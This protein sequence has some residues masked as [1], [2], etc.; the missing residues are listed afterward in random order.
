MSTAD[1]RHQ[2]AAANRP[3]GIPVA[4]AV[5]APAGSTVSINR[6][7]TP[8]VEQLRI[9]GH[10]NLIYW[11]PVWLTGFIMAFLTWM[12]PT[13]VSIGQGRQELFLASKNPGVI[14]A[15]VLF[16]VILITNTQ[17]RGL[18]SVV[19][20]LA[21]LFATV[22]IAYMGWWE[23]IVRLLPHLSVHMNLGF[24][25]F[26]STLLFV[27]WFAT[28]F[29][30]D[31]MHYWLVRPGQI[32]QEFVVGGAAKSYDTRGMVFEKERQDLFRQ[33]IIGLGSGDLHVVTT[34]ARH[35]E[36]VV[37]NVFFV[38]WK[39]QQIQKLIATRPSEF[40]A[41]PEA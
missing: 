11:W 15:V 41:P 6:P 24:Y 13:P 7:A 28:V 25:L 8:Q 36:L 34:G 35:E 30:F 3:T 32:T 4:P 1:P 19:V 12:D 33:W 29:I 31:R 17:A 22:L 39:V 23:S 21:F 26:F 37:P 40:V 16:L 27:V 18:A 2:P 20:V 38:D 10:S 5:M 14:F 9:Y